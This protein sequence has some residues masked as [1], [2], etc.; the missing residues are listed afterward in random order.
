[1]SLFSRNLLR[2]AADELEESEAPKNPRGF[3]T[4]IIE[5]VNE[6]RNESVA[7]LFEMEKSPI[8]KKDRFDLL[9]NAD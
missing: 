5:A 6:G 3:I 4:Q 7:I 1:M 2:G 9:R 8:E